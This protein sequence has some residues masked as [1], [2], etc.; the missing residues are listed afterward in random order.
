MLIISRSILYTYM[1][2]FLSHL[3]PSLS[4][5]NRLLYHAYFPFLFPFFPCTYN[6]TMMTTILL[7]SFSFSPL[8]HYAHISKTTLVD[9]K[10]QMKNKI[11]K[12]L[13]L[14]VTV[15]LLRFARKQLP[16]TKLNH[17]ALV[18]DRWTQFGRYTI[19]TV[20]HGLCNCCHK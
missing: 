14:C 16:R 9:E 11:A 12:A 6:L 8:Q 10:K 4:T 20:R 17:S 19:T 13:I 15:P 2:P 3:I 7:P 1:S 18:P 5:T